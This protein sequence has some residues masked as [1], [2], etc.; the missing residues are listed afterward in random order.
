MT[1]IEK[2]RL[3]LPDL[4]LKQANL[5]AKNLFMNLIM[6]L[7]IMTVRLQIHVVFSL[8]YHTFFNNVGPSGNKQIVKDGHPDNP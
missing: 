6:P 2:E 3:E 1:A 8:G 4:E 5:N 7:L